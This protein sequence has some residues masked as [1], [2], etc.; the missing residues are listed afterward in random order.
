MQNN[1]RRHRIKATITT[2][3]SASHYGQPVIVLPDGAALDLI[4]WVALDY[5][6]VKASNKEY[7][8][9]HTLGLV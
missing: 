8:V 3:H 6:V 5:R 9:L 7:H 2:E 1:Q 4:S